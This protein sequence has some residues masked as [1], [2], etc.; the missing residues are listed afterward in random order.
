MGWWKVEGTE[1]LVGDLPMESLGA[2]VDEIVSMYR[3]EFGRPPTREEWQSL[4]LAVLGIEGLSPFA[5]G[6]GAVAE[7]IAVKFKGE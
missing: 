3:S 5:E 2:A 7:S 1:N 6:E 4:L